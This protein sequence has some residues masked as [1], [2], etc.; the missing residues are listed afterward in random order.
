MTFKGKETV[1]YEKTALASKSDLQRTQEI[2]LH[3]FA[4]RTFNICP[5]HFSYSVFSTFLDLLPAL[6]PM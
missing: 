2:L 1:M 3:G 5:K 6:P 4:S